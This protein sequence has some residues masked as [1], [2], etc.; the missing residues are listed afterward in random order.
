MSA[1]LR[2][3]DA[4]AVSGSITPRQAV[5]AIEEALRAG[6]DP[7]TDP[8]R[9]STP[10]SGGEFLL[11]PSASGSAAGV[12]V[13]TLAPGNPVFGVPRIQGIYLLCDPH[14]LTPYAV[15]DGAAVTTLRTPAVSLAAVRPALLRT[16]GPLHVVVFGAGPQA[17]GHLQTLAD[18]VDGRRSVATVTAVVRS[19]GKV[20]GKVPLGGTVVAAGSVEADRA[21]R[22]AG[23]VICATT[24]RTALFDSAVV[25]ADVV[26][27]AV[28][29]HEPDVRELD[30]ALLGRAQVVVEDRGTALRECGDVVLAVA[31]GALDPDDL[32]SL[33]D[34]VCSRV[35]LRP[36]AP[37]VF[38]SS[39]MSWE[40][41]VIAT[42]V[43]AFGAT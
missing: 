2:F 13:L 40:D 24:A 9:T 27:V 34:V 20:T 15:L 35:V 17:V 41:L 43:A 16:S 32:V 6:L 33:S 12:K 22:R 29:S 8:P 10:V 39:G 11:M 7:A 26:V 38:K 37:V 28:G 42:A 3:L 18:V 30:A 36:D 23:L 21:L 19:P 14:T 5:Q 31:E 25:A 1:P 4:E